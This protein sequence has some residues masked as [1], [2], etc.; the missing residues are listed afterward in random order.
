MTHL[1]PPTEQIQNEIVNSLRDSIRSFEHLFSTTDTTIHSTTANL[2]VTWIE[3]NIAKL[4]VPQV[5]S[6]IRKIYEEIVKQKDNRSK[7]VKTGI[8]LHPISENWTIFIRPIKD[9]IL[10]FIPIFT[11]FTITIRDYSTGV[12][13]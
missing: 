6:E 7:I 11:N 1:P 12:S 4:T 10:Y 9:N 3:L 5:V 13:R 2:K 8:I